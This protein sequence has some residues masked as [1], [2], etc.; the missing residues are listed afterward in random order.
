MRDK[1]SLDVMLQMLEAIVV[2]E[3]LRKLKP[4]ICG[5]A[6]WC[7]AAGQ[8]ARDVDIF[9]RKG[10]FARRR[11]LKASDSLMQVRYHPTRNYVYASERYA[12][13][14]Y[15]C[16]GAEVDIDVVVGKWKNGLAACDSFDY[17]HLRVGWMPSDSLDHGAS[18]YERGLLISIHKHTVRHPDVVRGKI[19]T[20]LWS[21]EDA[22]YA[23]SEVFEQLDVLWEQT[24]S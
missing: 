10:W 12:F 1:Y 15:P 13:T 21:N 4:A 22:G 17:E 11:V 20:D 16:A 3:R 8:T 5:N 19:V 18:Y 14:G 24:G 7:W 9:M 2:M 6:L 23:L